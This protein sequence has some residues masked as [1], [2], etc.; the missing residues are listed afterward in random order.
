MSDFFREFVHISQIYTKKEG[1]EEKEAVPE[2][3]T[4]ILISQTTRGE[5]EETQLQELLGLYQ[6]KEQED[7]IEFKTE[8][9]FSDMQRYV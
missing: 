3:K 5:N 6:K 4:Q 1:E 8:D 2:K 9:Q 7:E